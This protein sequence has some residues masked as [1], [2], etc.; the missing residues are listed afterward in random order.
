MRED[1]TKTFVVNIVTVLVVLGVIVSGYLVFNKKEISVPLGNAPSVEN[2]EAIVATGS[3]ISRTVSELTDLKK[4]VTD[5]VAV[6][7]MP[8]FMRL[9]NFSVMVPS[10]N[11]GRLNP[12]ITPAWKVRQQALEKAL[13]KRT[14]AG[15]S[16]LEPKTAS[17]ATPSLGI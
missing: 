1:K 8:E 11:V 16:S 7:R 9:E 15:G 12:F 3:E 5:S 10:E 2:A 17:S 6:F 14:G 13:A 4:A